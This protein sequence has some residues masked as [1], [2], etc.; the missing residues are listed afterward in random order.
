MNEIKGHKAKPKWRNKYGINNGF[1]TFLIGLFAGVILTAIALRYDKSAYAKDLNKKASEE[2]SFLLRQKTELTNRFNILKKKYEKVY[3]AYPFESVPD[4]SSNG[5][6]E[7]ERTRALS[8][9]KYMRKSLILKTEPFA[10]SG[11]KLW[12]VLK[13]LRMGEDSVSPFK[14]NAEKLAGWKGSLKTLCT[15]DPSYLCAIFKKGKVEDKNGFQESWYFHLNLVLR[16]AKPTLP[17]AIRKVDGTWGSMIL[18]NPDLCMLKEFEEVGEKCKWNSGW[19]LYPGDRFDDL[20]SCAPGAKE[21]DCGIVSREDWTRLAVS[22]FLCQI[23]DRLNRYWKKLGTEKVHMFVDKKKK[24]FKYVDNPCRYT[25]REGC[26]DKRDHAT[27]LD[28][29]NLPPHRLADC[30]LD[31]AVAQTIDQR[32]LPRDVLAIIMSPDFV[33]RVNDSLSIEPIQEDPLMAARTEVFLR[34]LNVRA[35]ALAGLLSKPS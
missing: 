18:F 29:H 10:N 19:G 35:K 33:D 17:T 22:D 16:N 7:A 1:M 27:V 21:E 32:T 34:N 15:T 26:A 31:F 20:L 12:V 8:L 25:Q 13:G 6:W 4:S 30:S 28:L 24:I 5:N 3:K 14:S 11:D 9:A 23:D 2:R